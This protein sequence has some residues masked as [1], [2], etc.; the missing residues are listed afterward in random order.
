MHGFPGSVVGKDL[1]RVVG[2]ACEGM[3]EREGGWLGLGL[4]TC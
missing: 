4:L 2:G 1:E 3:N